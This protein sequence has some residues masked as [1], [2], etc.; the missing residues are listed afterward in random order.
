MPTRFSLQAG[1][2]VVMEEKAMIRSGRISAHA[3][4]LILTNQRLVFAKNAN[5]FHSL[6]GG[7]GGWL[8]GRSQDLLPLDTPL[9]DITAVER[10][11]F[12]RNDKVL[13][14]R[15]SSQQHQVMVSKTIDEWI[16]AIDAS[17]MSHR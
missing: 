10:T 6:L 8:A 16:R 4:K 17:R 3:G 9:S 14:V 15:T 2:S 1:E 11:R 5:P 13:L 12:G 7:L